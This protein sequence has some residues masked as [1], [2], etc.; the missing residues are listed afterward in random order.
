MT[1]RAIEI[2]KS[3]DLIL[4]EDTRHSRPLL[5]HFG[6]DK[7]LKSYHKFNERE[8]LDEVTKQLREGKQIA[9]ISD[10]GMPG[11]ADPGTL[12]VQE[13]RSQGLSVT[14]LPGPCALIQ[15]LAASGWDTSRFQFV[16]YLPRKSG[17][18]KEALQEILSYPAP[19]ASYEAPHRI[20]DTLEALSHLDP[21]RPL[22]VAREL[23][24]KFEEYRFGTAPELLAHYQ[25]HPPLGEIVLLI[26]GQ[27]ISTDHWQTL[28]PQEHVQ[29]MMETYNLDERAAIKAVATLR[30]LPKRDIYQTVKRKD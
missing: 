30:G 19:T 23:T 21:R 24:K 1:L 14:A 18:L 4:C 3:C 5:T 12:L 15:A 16:G 22:M 6:I 7:P 11:I 28:S 8:R 25:E 29:F 13:C 26:A 2:L 10:A 20:L 27:L 17:A 9:L